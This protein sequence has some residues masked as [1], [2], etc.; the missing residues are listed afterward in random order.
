MSKRQ[1]SASRATKRVEAG[2]S[3]KRRKTAK[4][5]ATAREDTVT[6][7]LQKNGPQ[8]TKTERA[9]AAH[10]LTH[11]DE[12]AFDTAASLAE[13]LNVSAA[14]I[15]RFCRTLGF[16][17]FR[18]LK[19]GLRADRAERPWLTGAQFDAFVESRSDLQWLVGAR[20][21]AA[22]TLDDVFRIPYEPTW[23]AAIKLLARSPQVWI[24]GF[25]TERG[26]GLMFAN[27][28]QHIRPGVHLADGGSGHFGDA[29]MTDAEDCIV[30]VHL[31]RYARQSVELAARAQRAGLNI[32]VLTDKECL[33]AR[34]YTEFVF[35]VP[36][37]R[38]TAFWLPGYGLALL[39]SLL[40]E[41]VVRELGDDVLS[42]LDRLAILYEQFAEL[43]DEN[44]AL[45]PVQKKRSRKRKN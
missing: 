9:I 44:A 25:H 4:K 11:L 7:L 29:L 28:L 5:K 1:K 33:W 13:K 30:I 23:P 43:A 41:D 38:E 34:E 32:I 16:K 21:N 24:A 40:V 45:M 22:A 3:S 6:D 2:K 14:T 10:I 31:A 36:L 8:F 20:E 15:G 12:I 42:R 26:L 19:D 37:Q 35:S 39:I 27:E 17:N 18:M